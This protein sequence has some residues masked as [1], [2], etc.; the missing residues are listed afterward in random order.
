[1]PAAQHRNDESWYLVPD[2]P[3]A[4]LSTLQL[5]ASA[6]RLTTSDRYGVH[7][8]STS[9][10][11]GSRAS[12]PGS[13]MSQATSGMREVGSDGAFYLRVGTQWVKQLRLTP[14][15][16]EAIVTRL[17]TQPRREIKKGHEPPQA[18]AMK[19]VYHKD[20]AKGYKEAYVKRV[21]KDEHKQGLCALADKCQEMRKATKAQLQQKYLQ[22]VAKIKVY[23]K[24]EAKEQAAR[25]QRLVEGLG[26]FEKTQ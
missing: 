18:R 16:L 12:T 2:K 26:A 23:S 22:P 7:G 25:I 6:T 4:K 3:T 11:D 9:L 15:E 14:D 21:K 17:N 1:M 10:Q 13:K 20:A 5:E 8:V 19:L 24:E